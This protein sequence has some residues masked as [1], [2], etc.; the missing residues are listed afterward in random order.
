[1]QPLWDKRFPQGSI[2]LSKILIMIA[3]PETKTGTASK[4]KSAATKSGWMNEPGGDIMWGDMAIS[5]ELS[6]EL[7]QEYANKLNAGATPPSANPW[8]DAKE[9]QST[10]TKPPT[11]PNWGDPP[12]RQTADR[13]QLPDGTM[14]SSTM[15]KWMEENIKKHGM[16]KEWSGTTIT[17]TPTAD[18]SLGSSGGLFDSSPKPQPANPAQSFLMAEQDNLKSKSLTSAAQQPPRTTGGG[19]VGQYLGSNAARAPMRDNQGPIVAG[20]GQWKPGPQEYNQIQSLAQQGDPTAIR[21]LT[22]ATPPDGYISDVDAANKGDINARNRVQG[23]ARKNLKPLSQTNPGQ[24]SPDADLSPEQQGAKNLAL[25]SRT[26]APLRSFQSPLDRLD[27]LTQARDIHGNPINTADMLTGGG[28]KLQKNQRAENRTTGSGPGAGLQFRNVGGETRV[29]G[30]TA[31]SAKASNKDSPQPTG[32]IAR[33]PQP[34][35]PAMG[36]KDYGNL[37]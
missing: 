30:N 26:S 25:T 10:A 24:Y 35:K 23:N 5:K 19:P 17:N 33:P 32:M 14:G 27:N 37:R 12:A 34:Y 3:R 15:R 4:T 8:G 1:M 9:S 13:V 20:D 18:Q 36:Q 7:W 28:V 31:K 6:P 22:Q 21:Q 29:V 16:P 11:P 2:R